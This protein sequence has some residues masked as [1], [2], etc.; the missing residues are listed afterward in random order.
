MLSVHTT[1]FVLFALCGT[2]QSANILGFF[3]IPSISHQIVFQPIWKELS[4]R[5]HN[6][7]VITPNPL[8]DPALT[9]L[10][11]IDVSF[12]YDFLK[13][14]ATNK[15][16]EG[17]DHWVYEKWFHSMLMEMNDVQFRHPKVRELL[18]DDT[19][20]FDVVLAQPIVPFPAGFR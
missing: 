4:L 7:T 3:S 13:T 17:M 12:S 10:T 18:E 11:E 14:V 9:N 8:N 2:I 20:T 15:F 19:K 5:G 1:C 6:V 16:S